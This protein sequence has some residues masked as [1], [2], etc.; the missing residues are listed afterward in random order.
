MNRL[1][2]YKIFKDE[3]IKNS[4]IVPLGPC[5]IKFN[6]SDIGNTLKSES[7]TL[8]IVPIT[9]EIKTDETG[10]EMPEPIIT[11][12]APNSNLMF[13]TAEE[14]KEEIELGRKI[15]LETSLLFSNEMMTTLGINDTLSS[16]LK[17]GNL[18]I[19]TLDGTVSIELYNVSITIEP[20][21]T[22]KSDKINIFKLKVKAYRDEL[23]RDIKINFNN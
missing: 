5:K 1:V 3:G 23:G 22:F 18:K 11:A 13:K 12:S 9:E 20:G 19:E 21:Y 4:V 8:K 16:L 2:R 7:T 15:T 14:A 17:K 10:L 6:D